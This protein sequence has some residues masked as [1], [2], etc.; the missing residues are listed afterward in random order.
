MA[1]RIS[2]CV[3]IYNGE[4]YLAETLAC[5][6]EQ[7]DDDVEF[8]ALDNGSTDTTPA[9]LAACHDP[10]LRIE[11]NDT[12]L[13]L[14]ENWRRVVEL[15]RGEYI[16]VVCADDL[17]KPGALAAQAAILDRLPEI[18]LVAS[19]HD[20]ISDDGIAVGH[21]RGLRFLLGR[22]SGREVA[23]QASLTG[24]NPVGES[25][26]VMFRR[27]DY[28][29]VGGWDGEL[30]YPMDFD[31]WMKLLTCGDLYG[32]PETLAAYRVSQTSL[33]SAFTP[34]Q[35]QEQAEFMRRMADDRAWGLPLPARAAA[36]IS[37]PVSLWT[38]SVRHDMLPL[39]RAIHRR[40]G[41]A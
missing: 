36:R 4:Q 9:I 25:A 5:L 32:Q 6:C 18:S 12:V 31:M 40:R 39:V 22:H 26:A 34:R 3:P 24:H 2:V 23:L 30:V 33:T 41:A 20:V 14:A 19:R 29:A 11:R 27:R 28:D 15:S 21:G 1:P 38:W 10:R 13:P 16:K 37:G 7:N 35:Y 17:I 8:V